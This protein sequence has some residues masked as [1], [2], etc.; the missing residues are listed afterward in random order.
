MKCQRC[1]R[2]ATFHITDLIDGKPNELHL[3]EECAKTFLSP[4]EEE[5]A[6]VMEQAH[7][8]EEAAIR[9]AAA[10]MDAADDVVNGDPRPVLLAVADDTAGTHQKWREHLLEEAGATDNGWT[11]QPSMP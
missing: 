10:V 8:T 6:E 7:E 1:D 9:R 2:Q 4:S 5:A 11:S 3:C